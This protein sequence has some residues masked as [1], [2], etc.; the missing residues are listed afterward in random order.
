MFSPYWLVSDDGSYHGPVFTLKDGSFTMSRSLDGMFAAL[1][2]INMGARIMDACYFSLVISCMTNVIACWFNPAL[3]LGW[4][5]VVS[6]AAVT[7]LWIRELVIMQRV[8]YN[9]RNVCCPTFHVPG[10]SFKKPCCT[11]VAKWH[12][13]VDNKTTSKLDVQ[14]NADEDNT[15]DYL[16]KLIIDGF[17]DDNNDNASKCIYSSYSVYDMRNKS[18]VDDESDNPF[19][20][21]SYAHAVRHKKK[22]EQKTEQTTEATKDTV[23]NEANKDNTQEDR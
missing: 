14:N 21:T 20:E 4:T 9:Q 19:E 10:N 18:N 1:V 7:V 12:D 5:F 11:P 17:D 15:E 8:K 16:N 13:V 2:M 23:S 6:A 22:T 3:S